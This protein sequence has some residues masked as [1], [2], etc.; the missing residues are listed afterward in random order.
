MNDGSLSV[1]IGAV[2][3]VPPGGSGGGIFGFGATIHLGALGVRSEFQARKV[4]RTV[5][6]MLPKPQ[7]K[8][9]H[10]PT[11]KGA[12]PMMMTSKEEGLISKF[13][14]ARRSLERATSNPRI[15]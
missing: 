7:V 11:M 10:M 14:T 5:P 15:T 1:V 6:N 3:C 12:S 4:S 13:I 2:N 9:A 8:A